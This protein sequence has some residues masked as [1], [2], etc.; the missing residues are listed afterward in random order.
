MAA[1]EHKNLSDVNRH[2]PKG[3]ETATN[4]SILTKDIGTG[5]GLSDGGLQWVSKK[6]IKIGVIEMKGYSTGNGS[7]Y[8][9]AQTFQDGQAPFEHNSNYTSGTVGSATLDV[10]DFFK[11]GG[12]IVHSDCDVM[13]IGGWIALNASNTCTLAICKVTPTD[14]VSTA[15]TPTLI[16]EITITGNTLDHLQSVSETTFDTTSLN[17]G[18]I[19]FTMIKTDTSG[20]VVYFNTTME[21][22][23]KN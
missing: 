15:L 22:G 18:D 9:Y 14:N 8:E 13:K 20:N 4:D 3:F 5:D 7:T 17:Q 6:A 2:N 21:L 11:T 12:T 1:N 16:K 10:S 19:V 23:Y